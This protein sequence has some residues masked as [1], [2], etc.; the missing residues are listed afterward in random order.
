ME[1]EK[2]DYKKGSEQ[3][4]LC[5]LSDEMFADSF[6]NNGSFDDKYKDIISKEDFKKLDIGTVMD[7]KQRGFFNR[8]KK[9]KDTYE[10]MKPILTLYDDKYAV[11]WVGTDT[12]IIENEKTVNYYGSEY[13]QIKYKKIDGKYKV[14]SVRDEKE[15]YKENKMIHKRLKDMGRIKKSGYYDDLLDDEAFDDGYSEH[16]DYILKYGSID[17]KDKD[18]IK[19]KDDVYKLAKNSYYKDY[20][21]TIKTK[22]D[23]KLYD[24]I[25][26]KDDIKEQI[27]EIKDMNEE[28]DKLYIK[29][30]EVDALIPIMTELNEDNMTL[31]VKKNISIEAD[32][33]GGEDTLYADDNILGSD[34]EM[35]YQLKI[36]ITDKKKHRYKI[37]SVKKDFEAEKEINFQ[38]NQMK[39]K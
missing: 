7:K 36:K 28:M 25:S 21:E 16:L 38:Y 18:I 31:W 2:R 34:L 23:K 5:S 12:Y 39:N 13:R 14:T 19:I 15:S 10:K 24:K 8:N 9:L 22:I 17:T 37:K 26:S 27:K 6:K 35:I 32:N 4:K 1:Y 20:D 3:D 33:S 30:I 29:S 11:V